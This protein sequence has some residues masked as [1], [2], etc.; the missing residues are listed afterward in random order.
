[1]VGFLMLQQIFLLLLL[2]VLFLCTGDYHRTPD[3]L[4]RDY[5]CRLTVV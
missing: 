2:L 4:V 3:M 1:M 5:L